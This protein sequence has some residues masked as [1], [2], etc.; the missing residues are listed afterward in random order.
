[1]ALT[2]S[3]AIMQL[4]IFMGMADGEFTKEEMI[5]ICNNN[6]VYKKHEEKIDQDL[7]SIKIERG[8]ATKENAIRTLKS[9]SL[10]TQLDALA[11]VYHVLLADRKMEEGEKK[12]MLE[13]LQEFNIGIE[14]VEKRLLKINPTIV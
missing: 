9:R 6:P 12:L 13:L 5:E 3:E 8:E 14:D 7:L 4:T 1:M 10:N 2:Q 11:V